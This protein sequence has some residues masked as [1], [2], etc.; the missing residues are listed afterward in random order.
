[1]RR[2][3]KKYILIGIL[4]YCVYFLLDNH[5]IFNGI[6]F[7]FLKKSE[8]NFSYTFFELQDK[9]PETIMEIDDLR[10]DGIGNLLVDL[11]IIDEKEKIRLENK[12]NAE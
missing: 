12:Y 11:N 10:N 1:M 7:Y 8:L 5:I 2:K 6:D 9:K 4:I 3:I